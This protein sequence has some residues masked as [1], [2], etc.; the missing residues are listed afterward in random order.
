MDCAGTIAD[1]HNITLI[2]DKTVARMLLTPLAGPM[3]I[4]A[5]NFDGTPAA[6]LGYDVFN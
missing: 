5:H 4:D 2:I 1:A 6:I 3:N